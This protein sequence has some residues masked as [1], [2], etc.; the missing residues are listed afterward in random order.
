M[1]QSVFELGDT[2]ARE[3]MVPRTEMVWIEARQDAGPGDLARAA[4]RAFPHPG[5]RRERRRRRRR[6]LPQGPGRSAPMTRPTAAETTERVDE[7]MR[8]ACSCR[9]QAV[10]ELLREMQRDRNHMAIV[11]DE[12]GG[13]AGLVT[14]EDVL[15]EIVGEITDEYDADEVAPVE[16]AGGRRA[17]GCRPGCRSRTSASCS[18]SSSTTTTS[19]PS[20]AC[21]R[22]SSGRVPMPG[23]E[24]TWART[25]AARRGRP[26]PSRPGADRH[27][28]WS[29]PTDEP[30]Q[31]KTYDDA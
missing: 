23:A 29:S 18:T 30:E 13:I 27:R 3:V 6:R 1:I 25:A 31:P 16:A 28:A 5:D 17:T 14:I 9:V 22:S 11:V 26:R 8:P 20:A 10:D 21:W 15:E 2:I 19:T 24:V 12:Y 4:Q 7:V